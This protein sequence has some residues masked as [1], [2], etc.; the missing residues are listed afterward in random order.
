MKLNSLIAGAFCVLLLMAAQ[1]VSAQDNTLP[2]PDRET[3][4]LP[5]PDRETSTLPAPSTPERAPVAPPRRAAAAAKSDAGSQ[6]SGGSEQQAA[7]PSQA[8][9]EGVKAKK[10][11]PDKGLYLGLMAGTAF[12]SYDTADTGM[13]DYELHS[14]PSFNG[15]LYFGRDFGLVTAQAEILFSWD[16][17]DMNYI[18]SYN[19]NGVYSAY[20]EK[21][22]L[23]IPLI[24]K[25]DFHLG[26]VVLQPLAGPY[27]NFA[28]GDLEEWHNGKS[29]YDP[30][31]NPLFGRMFGGTLGIKA[32][33]GMIFLDTRYAM[34][35]GKTKA[36]NNSME[37][38]QQS[39]LMLNLGYQ[40][41]FGGK[42]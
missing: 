2:P 13:S 14:Y 12:H 30:Y 20:F 23:L 9:D 31:E 29:Y 37:I 22:S 1:N 32:G 34:D 18:G 26:P 25:L 5:A 10:T 21:T 8:Q 4:A 42:K 15:G 35:L 17:V 3:S 6:A 28:L 36:G 40:F 33:T 24:V 7:A 11:I 39:G 27:L 16:F 38:W 41:N 19:S